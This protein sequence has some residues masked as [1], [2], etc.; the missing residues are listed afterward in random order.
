MEKDKLV[1]FSLVFLT[2]SILVYCE[3]YNFRL[4]ESTRDISKNKV[5]KY[6]QVAGQWNLVNLTING[7]A[8]GP[9]AH[10]WSW[11]ESQPWYGGGIGSEA[12]P[13]RI[14]NITITNSDSCIEIYNSEKHFILQNCN[15][16]NTS[17]PILGKGIYFNNVSNGKIQKNNIS[18]FPYGIYMESCSNNLIINNLML[19]N[20]SGIYIR[21]SSTMVIYN[22]VIEGSGISLG[23][24]FPGRTGIY[25]LNYPSDP[26]SYQD[27]VVLNNI[28]KCDTAI[29]IQGANNCNVSLNRIFNCKRGISM[30]LIS[31]CTTSNNYIS[32]IFENGIVIGDLDNVIE[33]NQLFM[34]NGSGIIMS[35]SENCLIQYNQ[36]M[37]CNSS[38]ISLIESQSDL[39]F[40]NTLKRNYN[41]ISIEGS[42]HNNI[43]KNIVAQNEKYG[44][45]IDRYRLPYSSSFYTSF[46]N[47]V[48]LNII[49]HN[50][51]AGIHCY[52]SDGNQ[53]MQNSID[54]NSYGIYLS[55]VSRWNV[56]SKNTITNHIISGIHVTNHSDYNDILENL[57]NYNYCGINIT[58]DS[59][60]N[61]LIGNDLLHNT[62]CYN[63]ENSCDDTLI[64]DNLC[65]DETT[66]DLLW[67]LL[68]IGGL[69][70]VVIGISIWYLKRRK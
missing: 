21:S 58:D 15:L 51:N 9:Y 1:L 36:I 53:I 48:S 5:F 6:P 24:G 39:V 23:L 49:K 42:S 67:I 12:N 38:G 56:I 60:N 64:K 57:I 30:G 55:A 47:N 19:G 63:I 34:I 25:I 11:V 4:I 35:G 66:E 26:R 65:S 2:I 31:G 37:L 3:S 43:F 52:D 17:Q 59:D 20:P 44:I 70:I 27:Q 45:F 28:S 29:R 18:L 54:N 32:F 40:N 50:K 41:G 7:T 61:D 69:S 13:Y 16:Y 33:F 22:N 68:L 8:V 14:E 10:N 62:I 46:T